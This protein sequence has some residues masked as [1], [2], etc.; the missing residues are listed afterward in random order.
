MDI[1][2][3]QPQSAGENTIEFPSSAGQDDTNATQSMDITQDYQARIHDNFARKSMGR[4]V[5]FKEQADVRRFKV[6]PNITVSSASTASPQSSP[7][8][9]SEDDLPLRS[10]AT[11]ENDYPGA[12]RRRSSARY[13]MA[14]SDMDL[15]TVMNGE[16]AGQDLDADLDDDMEITEVI[17]GKL[18]RIRSLSMGQGRKP[19]SEVPIP[20]NP[21]ESHSSVDHSYSSEHSETMEYTV[22]LCQ[23]LRPATQD[24]AWVALRN[25]T[26]AAAASHDDVEDSSESFDFDREQ[27]DLSGP[28]DIS[29]SSM[30]EDSFRGDATINLTQHLRRQSLFQ[31]DLLRDSPDFQPNTHSTPRPS[32][33]I[34]Q[35]SSPPKL[36][37]Q[38]QS[39]AAPSA[40]SVFHPP[41]NSKSTDISRPSSPSKGKAKQFTAA[42][43]P[44]VSRSS[45]RKPTSP[46][47][48]RPNPSDNIENVD[49][50]RPSPAKRLAMADKWEAASSNP[51]ETSAGDSA[52][53][54]PLS[55]S[56]RAPFQVSGSTSTASQIPS[57][58]R[59][60]SGYFAKRK[61]L[62]N[63]TT[64][65][66]NSTR[67]SPKKKAGVGLGR[68]SVGSGRADAWERF[69]KGIAKSTTESVA[70]NPEV[71]LPTSD[72]SGSADADKGA[73]PESVVDSP[74]PI[75][76]EL[77]N[78]GDVPEPSV[79]QISVSAPVS[80][81]SDIPDPVEIVEE[82]AMELDVEAT[83][84]WREGVAQQDFAEDEQVKAL[85]RS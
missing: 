16:G 47:K 29:M 61:S 78:P 73:T 33:S 35:P 8:N 48:K 64:A 62:A 42:F 49:A 79:P 71:E 30:D 17:N 55:P 25:I 12:S 68:A 77:P 45:P 63:N 37:S 27:R 58:L 41:S 13:S 3:S 24:P 70:D 65:Q 43:A 4:R 22:P 72:G 80:D 82:Q 46:S 38:Q 34:P 32:V 51:H 84:Q 74:L 19:L 9:S 57:G 81:P 36:D 28:H 44:P 14:N 5:S 85:M 31:D 7:G 26:H 39:T 60:P 54:R 52:N 66:T 40:P 56:K 53:P 75:E 18:Q 6:D 1:F 10:M 23:A 67:T 69:D 15:T 50:S 21:D 83:E 76:V 11:N 20:Q 59:R 2:R